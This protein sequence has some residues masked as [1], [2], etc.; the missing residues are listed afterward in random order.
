MF[1]RSLTHFYDFSYPPGR[2]GR[3]DDWVGKG[4]DEWGS[5]ALIKLT[6]ELQPGIV[7][8][9]RLDLDDVE[10]GWDY[11]TPEQFMPRKWVEYNGER[12]FW[13]TCQTFSG[14]WGYHR[15]ESS[16]KSVE[17][18][19][20][21]L[22]GVV[23]RGGNLLLNVGPTGRGEFDDRALDRLSGMGE[24]M[25][26]HSRSIYGCTQA[27]EGFETP[28]DCR[29]TYNPETNRLYVHVLTW[30][31]RHLHMDGFGDRVAYA[32]LLNDASEI[33]FA[34][35]GHGG[36]TDPGQGQNALTLDLPVQKPDV[37]VPVV[38]LFLKE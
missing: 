3:P 29:L 23:S 10:G 20:Q 16:W 17:Q 26:R 9:D 31:F 5:E 1:P 25:K 30:P 7:V 13:E 28:Q 8:N 6:R 24:W 37:T 12:V 2:R 35:G 27:P 11:R 38:E 36:H 22:I 21:M 14:S 33:R 32:Q 19:V 18:L 34:R 4:R 15:D